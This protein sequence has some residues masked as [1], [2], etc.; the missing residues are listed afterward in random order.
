MMTGKFYRGFVDGALSTLG[1]VIGASSASV[2]VIIAA[3]FGGTVANGFSNLLSAYS[4]EGVEKYKELRETEAAMGSMDLRGTQPER[5][6]S[7]TT[8][9]MGLTDGMATLIGGTIPI[10]PFLFLDTKDALI[11][12]TG[13]IIA[14]VSLIGV[15]IGRLSKRNTWYSALKMGGLTIIVA[16]IV[17]LVQAAIVP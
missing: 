3:G 9:A 12:A 7:K 14:A 17:Y 8:I 13:I 11:M 6:I 10:I 5:R 4:A 2:E 1:I 15:Y 16:I